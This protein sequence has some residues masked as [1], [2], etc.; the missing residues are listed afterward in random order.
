MASQ[1]SLAK[2]YSSFKVNKKAK[3]RQVVEEPITEEQ[4]NKSKERLMQ[5]VEDLESK[6]VT[7]QL[8]RQL[9]A[10]DALIE[11]LD[12]K[13]ITAEAT[14]KRF[15]LDSLSSKDKQL[16]SCFEEKSSL[17]RR[18]KSSEERISS[19]T[20]QLIST[21]NTLREEREQVSLLTEALTEEIE[22]LKSQAKDKSE[23]IK[24]ARGDVV[25]MS[26]IVQDLN[27]VNEDLKSKIESLNEEMERVNSE[28]Y[29]AVK[30]AEQVDALE[31]ELKQALSDLQ[32]AQR[33]L[34]NAQEDVSDMK[35]LRE[36][37]YEASLKVT[38]TAQKLRDFEDDEWQE[39]GSELNQLASSLSSAGS[40]PHAQDPATL[41]DLKAQIKS[42]KAELNTANNKLTQAQIASQVHEKRVSEL[43]KEL[44]EMKNSHK[45]AILELQER[46]KPL[47]IAA[48]KA[49]ATRQDLEN[50]IE[51]AN[52]ET[53]KRLTENANLSEK[54]QKERNRSEELRRNDEENRRTIKE[55]RGEKLQLQAEKNSLEE[56]NRSKEQQMKETLSRVMAVTEELWRRDTDI[57]RRET[58]RL[59]LVEELSAL[60]TSIQNSQVRL[61]VKSAEDFAQVNSQLEAKE[62]EIQALKRL[63]QIHSQP[64]SLDPATQLDQTLRS[65]HNLRKLED[66]GECRKQGISLIRELQLD[67]KSHR[68]QSLSTE[69]LERCQALA[70]FCKDW[71]SSH[72]TI[73]EVI[74]RAASL[75]P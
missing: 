36:L 14:A 29:Q 30:R 16:K 35:K 62:R 15:D 41:S 49:I 64:H 21:E 8:L 1:R 27:R 37:V 3:Q 50:R 24:S 75:I 55:L 38:E 5:L 23:Q 59:K 32:N 4:E 2:S 61:K 43:E 73:G 12:A 25:A 10:R 45:E 7:A 58:Q 47:Q 17:Y 34:T 44:N 69:D 18:L 28:K 39:L 46:F 71:E 63:L 54:L 66:R 11:T 33:K 22:V 68:Q 6:D 42:L 67:L 51:I 13:I 52:A 60:K 48:E 70:D 56:E 40:Q 19:L 26:S 20:D 9:K 65:L 31:V 72:R 74:D 57:L 53:Q